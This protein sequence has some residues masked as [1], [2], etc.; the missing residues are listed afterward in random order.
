[1]LHLS[2]DGATIVELANT[3]HYPNGLALSKDG[4]TLLV[5][6]MLAGRVLSFPVAADGSLGV[7][8]VWARLRDLAPPTPGEDGYN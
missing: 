4:S 1:V 7:R 5:A 8:A 2:A 6:E 3:I